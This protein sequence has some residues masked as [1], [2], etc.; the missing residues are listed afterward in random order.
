MGSQIKVRGGSR[1]AA[2]ET[3]EIVPLY[4]IPVATSEELR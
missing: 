1:K 4:H 2:L 3:C